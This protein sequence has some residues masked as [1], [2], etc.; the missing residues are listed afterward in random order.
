MQISKAEI[1]DGKLVLS[2][3][4]H[5]AYRF[6]ALFQPGEWEI[7]KAKKKRSHSANSYM[8]V[9]CDE[10]GK[11][12]GLPVLDVYRMAIREVGVCKQWD[13]I[14]ADAIPTLKTGWERQ[15]QG[16]LFEVVDYGQSNGTKLCRAY[17]GSSVYN[18]KQMSR[19]IEHLIEDARALEIDVLSDKER[20]LLLDKWEGQREVI[21]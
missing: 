9:L 13:N 5:E 20:A 21:K 2:V 6:I 4:P 1:K 10:I 3:L 7:K 15:G 14:P 19:L 18:T 17:Y 12:I 11:A 16:W 8:W